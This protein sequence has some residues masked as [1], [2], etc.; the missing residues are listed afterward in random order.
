MSVNS[1]GHFQLRLCWICVDS[2][3]NNII[4]DSPTWWVWN[5]CAM[6]TNET[7]ELFYFH[8]NV[9]TF[10]IAIRGGRNEIQIWIF[11][12]YL[13]HFLLN[14]SIN[15]ITYL[16]NFCS[17]SRIFEFWKIY[18]YLV[19]FSWI[20]LV[21]LHFIYNI[22]HNIWNS[23]SPMKSLFFIFL[24]IAIIVLLNGTSPSLSK[25][26]EQY[27]SLYYQ[28]LRCCSFWYPFHTWCQYN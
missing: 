5:T 7:S 23:F 1:F 3:V 17:M 25:W 2:L 21:N 16:V 27:L 26:F 10:L 24:E 6:Q 14:H 8:W 4:I 28:N 19:E 12:V 18:G 15:Y 22:L 11:M 20:Y 9:C 13:P